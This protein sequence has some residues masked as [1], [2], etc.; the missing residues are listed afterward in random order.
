MKRIFSAFLFLVAAGLF[1]ARA[2]TPPVVTMGVVKIQSATPIYI[3]AEKGYFRDL[4]VDVKIETIEST[5]TSMPLLATNRLQFVVGGI[6]AAYWNALTKQLPVIL[7]FGTASSPAHNAVVVRADLAGTIKTA[8]DLKGRTVGANAPGAIPIYQLGKLL[9]T[10]KLSLADV[11]VRYIPL[12]QISIAMGNRALDVALISPPWSNIVIDQKIGVPW[13]DF[14]DVIRP[15]PT[16]I[17]A[18]TANADWIKQNHDQALRVF[19]AL[20]HASRDY[21]QAYHH[22][23]NRV[24]VE[25]IMVKY[26]LATDRASIDALP[27]QSRD[28]NG[29]VNVL[30]V[31]DIQEVFFREHLIT[32]KFPPEKLVDASFVD[33]VA[34]ELG[35]FQ[36]INKDSKEVGCR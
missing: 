21:C 35:P 31:E 11:D 9:E 2:Q 33:A 10:A 24:E 36:P 23:P 12:P 13:I 3:A 28:P 6:G 17:G 25:D 34:K 7:A 20:G 29:R 15:Q 30:S 19:L 27:W 32:Q 14:D 5:G 16:A 18:F 1:P 22:G 8:S 26:Q 4:G